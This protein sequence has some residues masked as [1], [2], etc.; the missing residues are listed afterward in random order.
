MVAKV[1]DSLALSRQTTQKFCMERFNPQK[2]NKV[3]SKEQF[4][5]KV[6]EGGL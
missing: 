3:D 4:Q 5:M 1:M 6:S 2:L